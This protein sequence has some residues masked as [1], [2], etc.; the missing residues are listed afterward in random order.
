MFGGKWP[1]DGLPDYGIIKLWTPDVHKIGNQYY[2]YYTVFAIY[3]DSNHNTWYV[4]QMGAAISDHLDGMSW[5]DQ[6]AIGIPENYPTY[7]RID[8]NLLIDGSDYYLVWGSYGAGLFAVKMANPPLHAEAGA[9]ITELV[10]DIPF[11]DDKVHP[12]RTEVLDNT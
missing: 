9:K 4:S 3:N 10:T 11:P 1:T 2:M 7:N 5:K 8:P 12:N 6:G